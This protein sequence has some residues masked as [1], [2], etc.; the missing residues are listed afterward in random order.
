MFSV[1][2]YDPSMAADWTDFVRI[3]RNGT[4]LFDR[5]YM[6]YHADRIADASLV[7]YGADQRLVALLPASRHG[8]TIVSHGG[9]TYGGLVVG[10]SSTTGR[11]LDMFG[12][13]VKALRKMRYSEL[14]YKTIPSIYHRTPADEDRYALFIHDAALY[15]REVLSVIDR[16]GPYDLQERRRRGAR[17]AEKSGLSL[18]E[19]TDWDAFWRVLSENLWLRHRLKPVHSVDEI[20]L[21]KSRFPDEIRLFVCHDRDAIHAG[22]VLYLALPTIHVQYTASTEEG[23]ANGA[24]DLLTMNLVEEFAPAARYFDFGNSNEQEGRYLNRG[25]VE[26]KEGF[27]ARTIC[28]DFYR[29]AL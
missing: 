20:K 6:D 17:K 24:L 22:M 9:L 19:S 18:S 3:S 1:M 10:R 23:R 12:D 4:F 29:L 25:L 7:I 11:M 27:G 14:I 5:K 13:L 16:T 8:A 15:R 28:H 2:P 21:L 26:F